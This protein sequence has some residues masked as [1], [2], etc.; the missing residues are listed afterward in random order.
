MQVPTT[1]PYAV[2][3][4]QTYFVPLLRLVDAGH[5]Q[6]AVATGRRRG[7]E[8]ILALDDAALEGSR[9]KR[10]KRQRMA[11]FVLASRGEEGD[12]GGGGL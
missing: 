5:A 11:D 6:M 9:K 8:E 4:V 12:V 10:S 1:C 2:P 3:G 7:D